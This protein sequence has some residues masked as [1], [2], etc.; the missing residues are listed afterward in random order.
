MKTLITPGRAN[1][2]T[3]KS[4][5]KGYEIAILHLAPAKESG[6]N[7][8]QFATKGCKDVCLN[9]AG[10]GSW[11]NGSNG[12]PNPIHTARIERTRLFFED[13]AEFARLLRKDIESLSRKALKNRNIPAVRLNGTS[14]IPWEKV[15]LYDG[16]TVMEEFPNVQF[17]DYTKNPNRSPNPFPN[18]H[19]TLSLSETNRLKAQ[20]W[21]T[22][23]GNV[24]VV[25]DTKRGQSLPTLWEQW[26]VIDGDT[27]DLR[28]LDAK[29]PTIIGLR[30]KGKAVNDTSGFVNLSKRR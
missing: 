12:Q 20:N 9:T 8:C 18:Y 4:A 25:F 3:A 6:Y 16:K 5:N 11:V 30:A 10:R 21:L 15:L 29:E 17:Y 13:R 14:D 26:P 2:K 7:V 27:H 23:G 1:P 24:A 22:L 28:M 19:L